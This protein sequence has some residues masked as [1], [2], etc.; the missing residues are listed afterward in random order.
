VYLN[1]LTTKIKKSTQI[2]SNSI[3]ENNTMVV[4]VTA[5]DVFSKNNNNNISV[6]QELSL[7]VRLDGGNQ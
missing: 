1:V 7:F 2:G 4:M 5:V 3:H 6:M